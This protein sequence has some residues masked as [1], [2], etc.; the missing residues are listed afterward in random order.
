MRVAWP[1]ACQYLSICAVSDWSLARLSY[2]DSV[3][4]TSS[5][6]LDKLCCSTFQWTTFCNPQRRSYFDATGT[7]QMTFPQILSDNMQFWMADVWICRFIL[8]PQSTNTARGLAL[9]FWAWTD[10]VSRWHISFPDIGIPIYCNCC[11]R[12]VKFREVWLRSLARG[13]DPEGISKMSGRVDW[14]QHEPQDI[15]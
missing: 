5:H 10:S 14:V 4:Y 13:S 7:F 15:N 1:Y 12:A 11:S 3:C 2:P 9:R 6:L 8:P